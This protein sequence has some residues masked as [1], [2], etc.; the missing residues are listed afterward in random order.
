MR[1]FIVIFTAFLT[2]FLILLNPFSIYFE[3]K[4]QKEFFLSDTKLDELSIKIINFI[5]SEFNI[6]NFIKK[7]EKPPLIT[8]ANA[9][10]QEPKISPIIE[11]NLTASVEINRTNLIPKETNA[12]KDIAKSAPT[13]KTMLEADSTVILIGDS[14]MS[15]FGW[16]LENTLKSRNVRV[17]NFA[18]S[19]T[20]L[21]NKKFYDWQSELDKILDE[22][23]E[24][25]AILMALFGANDTYG[26]TFDKTHTKFGS[27]KWESGYAKRVS[28]IY[29]IAQKHD[30]RIVW[31]GMPCME[32]EKYSEKMDALNQIYQKIANEK[33]A[34]FIH[35]GDA[36]CSEGKFIKTDQNKKAL[37]NEDGMHITTHGSTQAAR[38]VVIELLK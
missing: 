26:Y 23:E 17:K 32:K 24:K 25:D 14:I 13:I 4:Y 9:T 38:Y 22:N 16:G 20:G 21:L 31:L 37:R 28:E 12:T 35:L 1:A 8:E 33:G 36:L 15:A 6:L 18:K 19:S 7:D 29:E 30:I 2:I 34:K 11:A 10:L 27:P 5:N 3:A